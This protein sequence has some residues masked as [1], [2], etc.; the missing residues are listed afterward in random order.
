MGVD[1]GIGEIESLG[2]PH[3]L[4]QTVRPLNVGDVKV[5]K[6]QSVI[7]FLDSVSAH[8]DYFIIQGMLADEVDSHTCYSRN[9]IAN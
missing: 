1:S 5:K 9:P 7:L 2:A 3:F 8:L 4:I 6:S